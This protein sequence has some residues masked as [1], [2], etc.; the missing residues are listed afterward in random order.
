[1]DVWVVLELRDYEQSSIIG[2]FLDKRDADVA[3]A[4]DPYGRE[5][6]KVRVQ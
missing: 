3:V 6:Y 2:V 1:M 4:Q 5:A